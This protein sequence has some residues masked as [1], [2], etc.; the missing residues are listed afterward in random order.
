[1]AAALAHLNPQAVLSRGYSIAVDQRS[2]VIRDS[3]VLE[4]GQRIAVFFERGRADANVL[5]ASDDH[6]IALAGN[7]IASTTGRE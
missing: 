4:P 3:R 7:A 1:L 5:T 6:G 2:R